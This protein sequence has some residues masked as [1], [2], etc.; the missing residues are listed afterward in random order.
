MKQRIMMIA[1]LLLIVGLAACSNDKS[2]TTAPEQ[3]SDSANTEESNDEQQQATADQE[4]QQA[5]IEEIISSNQVDEEEVVATVNGKEVA[6]SKYNLMLQQTIS[7][8]QQYGQDPSDEDLVKEQTM[9]AVISQEILAQ[10]LENKG[11]E[12]KEAD[13]NDQ[14]EKFKGNFETD[15]QY[16]DYLAQ[17]N[18]SESELLEQVAYD[19]KIQQYIDTEMESVEVSDQD[20]EDYYEQLS[21]QGGEV[22]ELSEVESQIREQLAS[23]QKSTKLNEKIKELKEEAEIETLI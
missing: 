11:I 3:E 23:Q 12:A 17:L 15:K 13:I 5:D 4:Q 14:V 18:L 20:V 19:I 16:K 1:F 22:P 9:N 21:S 10:E 7:T 2:E 6:G 8:L